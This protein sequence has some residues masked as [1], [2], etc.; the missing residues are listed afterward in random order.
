MQLLGNGAGIDGGLQRSQV[1]VCGEVNPE[2]GMHIDNRH[3][4]EV[5]PLASEDPGLLISG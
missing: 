5:D 2:I 4:V 1:L 3:A